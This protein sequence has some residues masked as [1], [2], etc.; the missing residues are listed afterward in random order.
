MQGFFLTVTL[1]EKKT[2]THLLKIYFKFLLTA[3]KESIL[4]LIP[5]ILNNSLNFHIFLWYLIIFD[6]QLTLL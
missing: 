6:I 1:S 4:F 3:F 2:K 5:A